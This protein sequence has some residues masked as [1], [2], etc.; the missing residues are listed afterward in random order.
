VRFIV[1]S[2]QKVAVARQRS[3][4]SRRRFTVGPIIAATLRAEGT[5]K[6]AGDAVREVMG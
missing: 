4:K 3:N 5:R 6:R 1:L 2:S